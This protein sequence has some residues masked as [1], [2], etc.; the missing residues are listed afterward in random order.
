MEELRCVWVGRYCIYYN[1]YENV[2]NINSSVGFQ[3]WE[4]FGDDQLFVREVQCYGKVKRHIR[5]CQD[6]F[7]KREPCKR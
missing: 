2:I 6:I 5:H 7:A 4:V 1:I 3:R